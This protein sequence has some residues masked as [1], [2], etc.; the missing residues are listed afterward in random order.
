M[1]GGAAVRVRRSARVMSRSMRAW[2]TEAT[3][4]ALV[5]EDCDDGL[6][7]GGGDV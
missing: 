7:Q 1:S 2:R 6:S 5:R 4:L 3:S